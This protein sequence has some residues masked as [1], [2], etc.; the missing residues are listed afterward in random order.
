MKAPKFTEAQIAYAAQNLLHHGGRPRMR[1][2]FSLGISPFRL[3]NGP[4]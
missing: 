3:Q 1:H 2:I 4:C